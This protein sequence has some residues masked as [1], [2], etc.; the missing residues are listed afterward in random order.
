[1]VV[2]S[3]PASASKKTSRH[4]KQT[5]DSEGSDSESGDDEG[6][7]DAPA[8]K[9]KPTAAAPKQAPH[10]P[11]VSSGSGLPDWREGTGWTVKSVYRKLRSPGEAA[12][13][14]WSEPTYWSFQVKKVKAQGP[15]RQFYLQVRST[16]GSRA[17]LASL[18]FARYPV[19]GVDGLSLTRGRFY[20]L[21]SGQLKPPP[22]RPFVAPGEPPH[23]VIA[24]EGPIP[25][26][27]PALPF[28][29]RAPSGT[30]ETELAR[31]FAVIEKLENGKT[32]GR[33][34]TQVEHQN[35]TVESFA[36]NEL[37]EY[38]KSKGWAAPDLSLVEMRRKSDNLAV[39][40]IWSPRLPWFLY[41][42][43][44]TMRSWL[45]D[46]EAPKPVPA[47]SSGAPSPA[48]SSGE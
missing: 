21:A 34:V 4:S 29:A 13:P 25:Y 23:P 24:D 18:Y 33:D 35:A 38:L 46:L 14:E 42:E 44:P 31:T 1:V 7:S 16:D 17:A 5:D 47:P 22:P 30:K 41:S 15:A 43:S 11:V 6:D 8:K 12:E 2:W 39:K 36:G 45:W 32:A 37:S 26:D 48:P 40:Q 27:F 10:A 19:G 3:Q 28:Q 20:T 9:T